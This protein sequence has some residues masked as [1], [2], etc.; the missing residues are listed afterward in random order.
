[1]PSLTNVAGLMISFGDCSHVFH[2]DC[3]QRWIKTR[4]NCPL[5]NQ[6][7]NPQKMEKINGYEN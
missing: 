3:I 7:W 6:E 5:C 1:M 4:N 2:G